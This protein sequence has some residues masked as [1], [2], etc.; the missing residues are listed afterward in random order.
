[1]LSVSLNKTLAIIY[2]VIAEWS[3]WERGQAGLCSERCTRIVHFTRN[4]VRS[5][6]FGNHE[7]LLTEAC[8]VGHCRQGTWSQTTVNFLYIQYSINDG[9]TSIN[10]CK[11]QTTVNFLYIQYSINNGSTSINFCKSQ[12]TVNFCIYNIALM[13]VALLLIFVSLR[14]QLIFCIYNIALITVALLLIF[15]SLR[16]QL[17]FVYIIL[18]SFNGP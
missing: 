12:T 10:F 4:C 3:T 7:K 11:S 18:Y 9:S 6:C 15:V 14:P 8:A 13:M 5:N 2:S 17:I 16:P 1:M